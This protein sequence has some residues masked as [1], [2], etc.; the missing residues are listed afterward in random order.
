MESTGSWN[1][2]KT[3]AKTER[4]QAYTFTGL[5]QFIPLSDSVW[6]VTLRN[7]GRVYRIKRFL[8]VSKFLIY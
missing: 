6:E 4:Y 1:K 3:L 5:I 2:Q 8:V 7:Y